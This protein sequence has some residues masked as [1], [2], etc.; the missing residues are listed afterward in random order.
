MVHYWG[1]FVPT[2][3]RLVCCVVVSSRSENV[4]SVATAISRVC[5]E[6]GWVCGELCR[7]EPLLL[8]LELWL[9]NGESLSLW[10]NIL[11][12]FP[13]DGVADLDG[14]SGWVMGPLGLLL[15]VNRSGVL[16]LDLLSWGLWLEVVSSS[17]GSTLW[18][19]FSIGELA[20]ESAPLLLRGIVPGVKYVRPSGPLD[21]FIACNVLGCGWSFSGN[22]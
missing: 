22:S 2:N 3:H 5:G 10:G 12:C 14:F 21:A 19:R 11:L 20:P 17:T 6:P 8:L 9:P 15:T 16:H 18:R 13:Y 7:E 4:S 1:Q